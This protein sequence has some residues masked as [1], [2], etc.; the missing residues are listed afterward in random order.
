MVLEGVPYEEGQAVRVE[1]TP[2]RESEVDRRPPSELNSEE[3]IARM[4]RV[5]KE[6][7]ALHPNS[8]LLTD[9]EVSRDSIYE[10]ERGL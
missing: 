2:L 7:H 3:W 10:D 9:H 1:V 8:P 6:I 5:A 4:R